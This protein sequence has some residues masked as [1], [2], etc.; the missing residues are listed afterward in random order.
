M[1][2]AMVKPQTLRTEHSHVT[3]EFVM[4]R[5]NLVL[6]ELS[7]LTIYNIMT[8]F[9]RRVTTVTWHPTI[10]TL[11]AVGSKF[12]EILIWKNGQ[13]KLKLGQS[14]HESILEIQFSKLR[15]NNMYI[16]DGSGNMCLLNIETNQEIVMLH[17]KDIK[18]PWQFATSSLD[19]TVK[20]WDLRKMANNHSP[21]VTL[22]HTCGVN[23]GYFSQPLVSFLRTC[24]GRATHPLYCLDRSTVHVVEAVRDECTSIH[25]AKEN[26]CLYWLA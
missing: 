18:E 20:L 26:S 9:K 7:E 21:L 11:L 4:A 19:H 3:I 24:T 22:T 16:V 6:R 14:F 13:S 8:P 10:P 2:F 25:S 17:L 15:A 12:G 1:G 23:S 5:R